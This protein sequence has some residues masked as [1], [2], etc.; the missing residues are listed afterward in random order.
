[1]PLTLGSVVIDC[2]EPLELMPFWTA[3]LGY[4]REGNGDEF[5]WLI[6]PAGKGTRL[7]LQKV[8]T[9][10][11]G[12]NRIHFDLYGRDLNA[13]IARLVA[14]GATELR[15]HEMEGFRW[16]V[17]QDPAGNEFCVVQMH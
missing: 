15:R 1:M 13:E 10:T 8:E 7:G 5:I 9:P 4:E 17:M 16:C 3:A 14:L 2:E 12:K 6:D 11:P